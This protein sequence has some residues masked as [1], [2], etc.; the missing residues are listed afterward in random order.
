MVFDISSQPNNLLYADKG[1]NITAAIIAMYDKNDSV[2]P[3]APPAK[4]PSA[5]PAAP[6]RPSSGSGASSASPK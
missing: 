2:T 4:S 6:R 3:T 1:T 5:S